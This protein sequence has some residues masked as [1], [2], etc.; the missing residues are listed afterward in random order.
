[1]ISSHSASRPGSGSPLRPAICNSSLSLSSR[2]SRRTVTSAATRSPYRRGCS[3]LISHF[4]A[5]IFNRARLMW[6]WSTTRSPCSLVTKSPEV[7]SAI[8]MISWAQY[9][10]YISLA[11]S[12]LSRNSP[13]FLSQSH[14][15]LRDG[16]PD[17]ALIFR[18]ET[19]SIMSSHMRSP[20]SGL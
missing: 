18:S 20:S 17:I 19:P 11:I 10:T 15:A 8:S 16:M 4:R 5:S 14:I 12:Y 7:S 6:S 1:M 3:L 13:L 9:S 2:M